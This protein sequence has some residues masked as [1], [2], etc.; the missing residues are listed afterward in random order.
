MR[1][2]R[3]FIFL[4]LLLIGGMGALFL[5]GRQFL[6]PPAGTTAPQAVEATFTPVPT[7]ATIK[8]VVATQQIRRGEVIQEDKLDLVEYQEDLV[9]PIMFTNIADVVGKVARY[10]ME[11]YTILTTSLVSEQL[12]A[13]QGSE[14]ALFVKPGM[15]AI[16]IP[17]DRLTSISYAPRRGDHVNVIVTLMFVDLDPEFQTRLPNVAGNVVGPFSG[18]GQEAPGLVAYSLYTWS[19][20]GRAVEDPLL[21]EIFYTMPQE[22]QRPRLVSQTLIQDV[23]VLQM[24]EFPA[25]KEEVKPTATPEGTV[26]P[27]PTPTP[28]PQSTPTPVPPPQVIT[29]IVSPQDAVTLNYLIYSGARLTLVLRH[30]QD[31]NTA[32]TEAVT[33]SY[34][35][36]RYGIPIPV[37]LPYGLEPRIDNLSPIPMGTPTPTPGAQ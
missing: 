36:D 7:A 28:Q 24:G 11:P 1:R 8:V 4:A 31:T 18:A 35:L 9:L 30:P 13:D 37:K 12:G 21:E 19:P 10:D 22:P 29:L 23:V 17:I 20:F 2:G 33:L 27:Q 14:A 15:V 26:T 6:L 34:L 5:L 3:I 16:S 32:S 25:E